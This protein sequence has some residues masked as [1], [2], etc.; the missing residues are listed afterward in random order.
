MEG[1]EALVVWID[2]S[3]SVELFLWTEYLRGNDNYSL[4]FSSEL[5]FQE[6]MQF[7]FSNLRNWFYGTFPLN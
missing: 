6:E 2:G 7:F 5:T 3:D 4:N 1:K